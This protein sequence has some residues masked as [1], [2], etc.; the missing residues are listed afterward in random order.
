MGHVT[1]DTTTGIEAMRNVD[2]GVQRDDSWESGCSGGGNEI[3]GV[4]RQTG[5]R[6]LFGSATLVGLPATTF[7]RLGSAVFRGGC[8]A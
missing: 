5:G 1:T 4:Q 3:A 6:P 8:G 7:V 2:I